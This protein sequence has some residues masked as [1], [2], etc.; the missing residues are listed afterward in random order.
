[1][2]TIEVI[3]P[4]AGDTVPATVLFFPRGNDVTVLARYPSIVDGTGYQS[5]F[6]Y[7]QDRKDLDTD[8]L[9]IVYAVPVVADP[10]NAGATMSTFAVPGSDLDTNGA[11]WWRIDVLDPTDLRSTIGFGTLIVEAV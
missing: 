5:E 8:P 2:A 1:M 3:T 7:K 10:D 11:F 4:D 9:T 6:Y